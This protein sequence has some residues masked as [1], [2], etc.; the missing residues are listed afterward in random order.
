MRKYVKYKYLL[1]LLLCVHF[2]S[3]FQV[4]I[5]LADVGNGVSHDDQSDFNAGFSGDGEGIDVWLILYLF[6]DH[7][8]L[9]IIIIAVLYFLKRRGYL[10]SKGGRSSTQT[11]RSTTSG[12]QPRQANLGRLKEKDPLFSDEAFISKVNNMFIQLQ[13][14]WSDKQWNSIR[15]FET[16]PLFNMHNRQLQAYIDQNKTNKVENI[17]ILESMIVRYENDGSHDELDVY[18]RARMNDYV[19]DDHTGNV[20]KGNPN[21]DIYMRY[22]WT[23]IRKDS[24]LTKESEEQYEVTQCPNCG[25]NVSINASGQCE[26]CDSVISNGEY[27]WVL[28]KITVLDQK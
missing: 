13:T 26:Y 12:Y 4:D 18:I 20:L 7:P 14:A 2:L 21:R 15:P 3:V 11:N 10:P 27:D 16:D 9:A 22:I 17:G 19:V 25:A 24:V 8:I 28:S 6:K 5:V 1:S 23:L